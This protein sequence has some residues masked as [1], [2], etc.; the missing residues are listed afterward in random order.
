[1]TLYTIQ[2]RRAHTSG[3][4]AATNPILVEGQWGIEID[5]GKAK[6]GD[7]ETNWSSLPY[8]S[9][10]ALISAQI[11][12]AMSNVFVMLE[13]DQD[14]TDIPEGTPFGTPIFRKTSGPAL[15]TMGV[16]YV[17]SDFIA[18]E[19]VP[20]AL[21]FSGDTGGL[22]IPRYD[23][24]RGVLSSDD[25]GIA[26]QSTA[27]YSPTA[28]KINEDY[29]ITAGDPEPVPDPATTGASFMG[30]YMVGGTIGWMSVNTLTGGSAGHVQVRKFVVDEVTLETTQ[31]DMHEYDFSAGPYSYTPHINHFANGVVTTDDY[32]ST[33]TS[34]QWRFLPFDVTGLGTPVTATLSSVGMTGFDVGSEFCVSQDNYLSGHSRWYR[35]Q[36]DGTILQNMTLGTELGDLYDLTNIENL[37]A[38]ENTFIHGD[39]KE[40]LGVVANDG[41]VT[42]TLLTDFFGA[43]SWVGATLWSYDGK[44][45]VGATSTDE[46]IAKVLADLN[47]TPTVHTFVD[48]GHETIPAGMTSRGELVTL[49]SAGTHYAIFEFGTGSPVIPWT[50][51]DLATA[52]IMEPAGYGSATHVGSTIVCSTSPTRATNVHVAGLVVDP[53]KSYEIEVVWGGIVHNDATPPYSIGQPYGGNV[54]IRSTT[55]IASALDAYNGSWYRLSDEP[56]A[57]I[58][59]ALPHPDVEIFRIGPGQL[60]WDDAVAD[61]PT[62]IAVHVET[63]Y[64]EIMTALRWREAP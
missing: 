27:P 44:V 48:T 18:G 29:S 14:E 9:N 8:F 6:L 35:V 49:D 11:S 26:L 42:S 3:D 56:E 40:Y 52:F 23:V 30:P 61:S 25:I 7:G 54:V 37:G 38:V 13:A 33:Q 41:T 62:M 59:A 36:P 45:Y 22:I 50:E 4:W 58:T 28:I 39:Y 21:L 17:V 10:G 32:T 64:S 53:A 43:G 2:K 31:Q 60:Q 1:M 15:F 51:V 16:D 20:D 46:T 5:T 47:G 57:H 24:P 12:E 55:S 63:P 34:H 19:P